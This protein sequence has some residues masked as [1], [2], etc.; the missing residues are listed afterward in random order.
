MRTTISFCAL[1]GCLLVTGVAFSQDATDPPDDSSTATQN[2]A[3][4]TGNGESDDSSKVEEQEPASDEAGSDE[5][6]SELSP[7]L[8]ELRDR[9]RRCLAYYFYRPETTARRSPWGVMHTVVGF[10]VDTPLVTGNKQAN[11]ISWLCGNAPCNGMRL[12][13][14]EDGRLRLRMGPGYQG[15]E[16]Q[17]LCILA[18]SRV[19]LDYPLWIG[20]HRL[21]VSDLVKHEQLT[22]ESGTEL[23]F[24]LI[25]ISHYLDPDTT[26]ENQHGE[27]WSIARLIK[28]E[29]AQSVLDACCGGTHRM[30][31][32]SFA[33][34]K[35]AKSGKPMTGQWYRAKRYVDDYCE[36]TFKLQNPD[37]SFST[38]WFRGRANSGDIPRKFDTTGHTLE[39]LV[40]S[41][42]KDQLTDPRV[43]KAVSFL[44]DLMWE[45]RQR[46]WEIGPKGHAV[47][48]LALYDEYVFGGKPGKRG[49]QL[50]EYKTRPTDED[51]GETDLSQRVASSP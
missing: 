17:F 4:E 36:Y 3:A 24:K 33:V 22:C 50:A 20:E 38:N 42:P 6:E 1:L 32:F 26:W 49:E 13:Y 5:P 16:G 28:E 43:V 12:L 40:F 30:T 29:L 44:T 46:E 47:H 51:D 21:K 39:W 41:L 45:N 14:V 10:G 2:D 19:K 31:G 18:Q 34:K 35:R 11:A 23:T 9:V 37:G 7:E 15:H 25:G 8:T 27:P 48:A